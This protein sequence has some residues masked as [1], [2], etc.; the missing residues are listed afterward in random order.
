VKDDNTVEYVKLI[1]E[2]A[3]LISVQLGGN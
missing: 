2:Y 1:K 3:R